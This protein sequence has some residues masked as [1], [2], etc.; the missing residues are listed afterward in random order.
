MIMCAV[1]FL[2]FCTRVDVCSRTY[3]RYSARSTDGR[4]SERKLSSRLVWSN[5]G[6]LVEEA[7]HDKW[8]RSAARREEKGRNQVQWRYEGPEKAWSV[9]VAK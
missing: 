2:L 7:K 5:A 8:S 1:P 4:A 9:V 6:R 3:L